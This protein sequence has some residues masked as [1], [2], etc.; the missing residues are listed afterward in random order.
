[1]MEEYVSFHEAVREGMHERAVKEFLLN[2]ILPM[3]LISQK[4]LSE[5]LNSRSNRMGFIRT[6]IE[7]AFPLIWGELT[8]KCLIITI[9]H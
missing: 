8:K 2:L 7:N 1:M 3:L 4:R 5:I 9:C 6:L